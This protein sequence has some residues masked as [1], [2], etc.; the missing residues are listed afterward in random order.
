M[1]KYKCW[2]CGKVYDRDE[3]KEVKEYTKF[4]GVPAWTSYFVSP[5]CKEEVES[6]DDEESEENDE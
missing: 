4:W 3:L 1:Y 5:C 6:F 2:L